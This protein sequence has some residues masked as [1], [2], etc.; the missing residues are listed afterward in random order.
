MLCTKK[1][2]SLKPT[3]T[4][5]MSNFLF[6]NKATLN[7]LKKKK[8]VPIE[9]HKKHIHETCF[10]PR[11]QPISQRFGFLIPNVHSVNILNKYFCIHGTVGAQTIPRME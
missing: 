7:L 10:V 9:K 4:I 1:R 11:L 8:K 2:E 3:A 5:G 6:Q